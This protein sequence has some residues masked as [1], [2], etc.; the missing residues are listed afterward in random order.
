MYR[1]SQRQLPEERFRSRLTFVV[2]FLDSK[3]E[4]VNDRRA[5]SSLVR[6]VVIE[7]GD[8]EV[9]AAIEA[10]EDQLKI[11]NDGETSFMSP[12][13]DRGDCLKQ[14]STMSRL[15]TFELRGHELDPAVQRKVRIAP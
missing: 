12:F 6:L 15:R 11:R 13:Q 7:G 3:V 10:D 4:N 1:V 8:R 5:E 14:C 2:E 9:V